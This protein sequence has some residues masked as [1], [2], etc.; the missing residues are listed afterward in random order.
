MNSLTSEYRHVPVM[1]GEVLE[2]LDPQPGD[3]VCDCT[4][5]GAGHTVELARRIAPNG[6]SLGI[7]QDDMALAAADAR[8]EREA[9]DTE[10]LFLKGNF[11][12][13][14]ELLVQA[15][16]P[17]VDKFLFDL[18]VSSPQLDIPERGFSYHEDAPLDMRMDPG[19]NTLTADEVINTYTEADLA[20]IFRVYGDEKHANRIAREVVRRRAR[21]PI[22]TTLQLVDVVKEGIPAAARRKGGHPAR[23]VFQAVRIEVNDEL[24]VLERGLEAAVRWLNPGGRVAACVFTQPTVQADDTWLFDYSLFFA[25]ALDE[26]LQETDDTEA[27]NDLYDVAMQQIEMSVRM[28]EETPEKDAAKDAFIDWTDDL[29]KRAAAQAVIIYAIRY[30]RRLARRK[31]DYSQASW[32]TEQQ[33]KLRRGAMEAFWDMEKKCFVSD[34]QISP[35]SQIWMVL[36]DVPTPEE[37]AE[38]MGRI[39]AGENGEDI[40]AKALVDYPL[41]TPYMHHYYVTALLRAG[42]KEQARAHMRSYWGSML[43]A[44]ADTFWETWDPKDPNASPYGGAVINS[45]CHAWSC[46]PAFLITKYFS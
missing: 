14:D 38:L 16:E 40:F 42:L 2:Y 41:A 32:L 12:D 24:G 20:R 37:S 22:R 10:H 35:H 18:G 23:K 29:E 30:A 27:L 15:A 3:V 31:N 9:P 4:L 5:G 44:G 8:F 6:L 46:T 36:A 33:E 34:G 7:D 28:C 17:G 21:E 19:N 45:Y 39:Y 13:L 25:V 1:L 11:G 26:Y 43:E